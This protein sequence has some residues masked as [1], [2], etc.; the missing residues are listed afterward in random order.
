MNQITVFFDGNP[1]FR[2]AFPHHKSSSSQIVLGRF[3]YIFMRCWPCSLFPMS[4]FLT[5][6]SFCNNQIK[7]EENDW[8][9]K[10]WEDRTPQQCCVFFEIKKRGYIFSVILN[11]IKCETPPNKN[12]I[13]T[14]SPCVCESEQR[15][16]K[17]WAILR[18]R[19]TN[20]WA[21]FL[22]YKIART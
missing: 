9:N 6:S 18:P 5:T 19:A 2:L 21:S 8:L 22:R 13:S 14:I 12:T 3:I 10:S 7:M 16:G 15:R 11:G 1:I 17:K 20:K 4:R